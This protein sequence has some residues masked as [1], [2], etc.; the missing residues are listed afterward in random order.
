MAGK[1][2]GTAYVTIMPSARGIKN[3]ISKELKGEAQSAGQSSGKSL[4]SSLVGSFKGVVAAAGIGAAFKSALDAGGDLQQSFG[5]LETL[6]G[7]AA[8]A[9]KNYAIEAAKAGLSANDYA[10]QAVSFGAG[11]KQAFGGDVVAAA[12]AANTAILDMQDNSAKMGTD[13]TMI[14]NAY[15]GFAKQNYTMLDNLKLGYG[16]TKQE[17]ERLLADAEKL[18]GIKYD[19]NNLGDVYEAIHVIQGE[20]GLTGVAAQEASTTFT[21][22]LNAMK[23]AGQNFLANLSL[24]EDIGPSLDVLGDSIYNFLVGNLIPMVG[25]IIG[26]MPEALQGAIGLLIRGFNLAA[27]HADEFVQFGLDVVTQLITGLV[28]SLPYLAEAAL[29]LVIALG[30]ALLNAD[31]ATTASTLM[32]T[33]SESLTTAGSE[34]L[35]DGGIVEGITLGL[36]EKLP[37]LITKAGE[38]ITSFLDGMLT[39]GPELL[40]CGVELLMKIIEGIVSSIP[41]IITAIGQV[42]ANIF[43]TLSSHLPQMRESG[44]NIINKLAEGVQSLAQRVPDILKSIAQSAFN[45]VKS[46]DWIEL[47]RTVIEL[48]VAGHVAIGTTIAKTLQTLGK[49]AY[50]FFKNVNWRELGTNVINKIKEGL[51]ALMQAIPQMLTSIGNNA[52]NAFKGVNWWSVGSAVISGITSGISSA[53]GSLFSSLRSLAASALSAAKSALRIGSPSKVFRDSVGKWIPL[54][55]AA[56]IENEADSITAAMDDLT[57]QTLQPFDAN[58]AVN[59]TGA[60]AAGGRS[61]IN[62]ITI[63]P[64]AGMD[65]RTL[66]DLVAERIQFMVQQEEAVY[67]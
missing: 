27:N 52:M 50:D 20:L 36:S 26:A 4:G 23:A 37:E 62:N 25:N 66:A 44:I 12:E 60:G 40:E 42:I 41:N 47:G 49:S 8:D 14:Q 30:D 38:I 61:V 53:A 9:A 58:L 24:G 56:G 18:T 5:G 1:N 28:E 15:Q 16:G 13:I 45:I 2:L 35:G 7:D 57:A 21:G 59:A 17:M 48:I 67:A 54:G 33:I 10:E 51:S 32:T 39:H 34:I 65:E 19:I 31:W 11:L 46:I 6:Y 29:N 22:S 63:N 64:S 55:I 43:S 3:S